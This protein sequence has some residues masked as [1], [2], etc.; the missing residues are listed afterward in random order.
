[1]GGLVLYDGVLSI[2]E[3]AVGNSGR[4]DLAYLS[5]C[6]TAVG[7]VRIP[8]ELMT[9]TAAL[10]YSGWRHVVGTLWSV[11]DDGSAEIAADFY[12]SLREQNRPSAD[13]SAQALHTAIRRQRD[14]S[15]DRASVW[16][17]FVHYGP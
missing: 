9:L 4:G 10:Q 2:R 8:D 14:A 13:R 12:R 3:L 15:P 16:A 7:G 17:P 5:A 11:W 1:M 6:K